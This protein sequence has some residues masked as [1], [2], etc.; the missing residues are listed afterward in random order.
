MKKIIITTLVLTSTIFTIAVFGQASTKTKYI[1][2]IKQLNIMTGKS[3]IY[4]IKDKKIKRY[5]RHNE[6]V[7][8]RKLRPTYLTNQDLDSISNCVEDIIYHLEVG[9]YADYGVLDGYEWTVSIE[10][11]T[12]NNI[13]TFINCSCKYID[14]LIKFVNLKLGKKMLIYPMDYMGEK[15]CCSY[16]DN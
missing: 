10:K 6:Q 3:G 1:V 11:D 9:P 15:D 14:R 4:I 2:Q 8:R 16:E 5:V 7:T 13:Y 12:I